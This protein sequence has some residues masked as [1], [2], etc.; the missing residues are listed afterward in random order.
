MII[1]S[2]PKKSDELPKNKNPVLEICAVDLAE[3]IRNREVSLKTN[4]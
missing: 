3:K 1:F 4:K 2:G